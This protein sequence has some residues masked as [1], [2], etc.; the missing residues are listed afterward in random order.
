[1]R[2]S[3]SDKICELADALQRR[4]AWKLAGEQVVFTN[5][6]FDILHLGHVDYLEK[7]R[8]TGTKMIVGINSDASVRKLKGPER[9]VNTEYARA[10]LIASLQFVDLVI[11]FNEE[12]PLELINHLLPDILVKGDDYTVDTIVGAKEV[13]AAGG[14]VK[15]I[16]LV[17]SYSTTG[18]IQKLK[19]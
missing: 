2:M 6:C 4:S 11:V 9:P 16:P 3:T 13:M 12:T 10:R 14:Q 8:Q 19:Q 18:I 5:G 15:T 17:P 7:A 1:M